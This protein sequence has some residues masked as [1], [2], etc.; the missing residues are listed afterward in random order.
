VNDVFL[1]CGLSH[2]MIWNLC[3]TGYW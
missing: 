3:R 2:G 1:H